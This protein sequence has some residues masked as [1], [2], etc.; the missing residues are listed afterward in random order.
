MSTSQQA[1]V[2]NLVKALHGAVL[3]NQQKTLHGALL[4]NLQ[5]RSPPSRQ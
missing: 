5:Q 2:N 1:V 3:N 4:N